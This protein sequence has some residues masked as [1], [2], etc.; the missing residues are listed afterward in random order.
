MAT[1]DFTN[2]SSPYPSTL[3]SA[4]YFSELT[5]NQ[6]AEIDFPVIYRPNTILAWT[7]TDDIPAAVDSTVQPNEGVP[8]SADLFPIQQEMEQKYSEGARSV[9]VK[10]RVAGEAVTRMYHF[11]KVRLFVHLSNNK[12]AVDSART[13]VRPF[14]R[15]RY[16]ALVQVGEE[17]SYDWTP[18]EEKVRTSLRP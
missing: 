13:L 6:A 8:Y 14:V 5:F 10:L 17:L 4:T 12:M 15:R 7:F 16:R 1:S 11:S 18:G 9:A 2:Y 3:H